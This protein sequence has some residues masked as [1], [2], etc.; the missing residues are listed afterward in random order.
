MLLIQCSPLDLGKKLNSAVFL[1]TVKLIVLQKQGLI[2]QVVRKSGGGK[3]V[4][5][6]VGSIRGRERL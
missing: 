4:R 5:R 1:Q 6:H 2:G 3:S